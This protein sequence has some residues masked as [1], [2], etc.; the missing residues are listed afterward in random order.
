MDVSIGLS[1]LL[2]VPLPA[3]HPTPP[4]PFQ[5]PTPRIN[6]KL[7]E[8]G[9]KEEGK[10]LREFIDAAWRIDPRVTAHREEERLERERKKN[11]KEEAKRAQREAEE[12]QKAEEEAEK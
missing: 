5:T 6:A 10:R 1:W 7:R 3:S 12:R 9:K 8:K 4:P 11:E 2:L